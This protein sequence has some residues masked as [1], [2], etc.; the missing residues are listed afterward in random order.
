MDPCRALV[1]ADEVYFEFD[2]KIKC[3]GGA[4][5]D[6][7]KGVVVFNWVWLPIGK[8]IMT[9]C[10]NSWLSSMELSCAHV[11]HPVEATI[12]INILKGPCNLSKVAACT[13]G[14]FKNHIILYEA[15]GTHIVL[16][17]G[18]SVPLT[19]RVLAVSL[20]QKLVLFLV[21]GDV[22]EHLVLTLGHSDEV[23]Y[24]KMGSTELKV[25]VTWTAVLRRQRSGLFK[26]VGDQRLLL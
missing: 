17:E 16:G 12:A 5:K 21:G 7:S 15:A 8:E 9:I 22:F 14:N 24:R 1:P 4:T 11:H 6:F 26:M 25:Q 10:R 13:P 23:I 2:L 18:G 20:D 3:D 19:R